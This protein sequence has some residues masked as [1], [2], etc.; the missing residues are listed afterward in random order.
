MVKQYLKRLP[1]KN[2]KNARDLG[3]VPTISGSATNWQKFIRTATLDGAKIDDLSYLMDLGI[4]SIVDLR[5]KGEIDEDKESIR[6]I[7][8]NFS[9]YNVSLA[10]DREFSKVDMGRVLNKEVTVGGTYSNLIDNYSAIRE[11]MEI[12]ARDD[13][14]C[15][16]HCQEGKDR[17]GIISMILMG[18]AD[19]SKEDIIADY[20]VSSA[21]LG[22]IDLDQKDPFSIF[23]I[24][25]PFYMKEAYEYVLKNYG[26][27]DAYL[28]K[29]GVSEE[30]IERVRRKIVG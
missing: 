8:E 10:G 15:L 21:H 19:V 4:T 12:F 16:F 17:T 26:S 23:R 6:K 11:I 13:G 28:M 22:Y 18:L 5:R 3:G 1:L 9:Y 27:F 14:G 24:T 25:S 30:V 7:K 29:A 20:E 2:I